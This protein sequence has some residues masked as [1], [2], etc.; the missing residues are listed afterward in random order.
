[1][2]PYPDLTSFLA[3]LSS[4]TAPSER[5]RLTA[6][7]S[8]EDALWQ[9]GFSHIAGV[10]EAGRGPLAGPIVAAA[11]ILKSPVCGLNDSKRLTERKRAQLYEEIMRGGHIV[12]VST[13]PSKQIDLFGIQAAN[14][15]AM[16]QAVTALS[17]SPDFVLVDGYKL[18]GF[19]QPAMQVIKGDARSLS[20]AA[21][22]IV[23]KVT[24]DR[25]M[26]EIDECYPGYGFARHKGYGTR[27]HLE[28]IKRLGACPEHRQ[29]FA[30]F[31]D[32][33]SSEKTFLDFTTNPGRQDS[34]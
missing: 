28:A 15:S 11:V 14:Q 29:S 31:T 2:E 16:R 10:D 26:L 19:Q 13:I 18:S 20:I 1:M 4:D 24:R 6:M 17:V 33:A 8:I 3:T 9:Q 27:Q 21:A 32:N 25:F 30:P 7:L 34:E 23:A 22:S 5:E 12:S